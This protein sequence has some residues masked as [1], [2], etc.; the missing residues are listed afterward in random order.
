MKR[1]LFFINLLT[2]SLLSAQDNAALM[3]KFE[4]QKIEYNERFNAYVEK[5]YGSYRTPATLKEIEELRKNLAGFAPDGKPY[6]YQEY[7]LDQVKNSNADFIQNGSVNGLTGAFNGEG[8]KYTVFDGGRA[9][10]A[11]ILFDNLPNRVT[12]Y[13]SSTSNYSSHAT[14]VTSFIGSKDL[15][16]TFNT[17]RAVNFRGIAPNSTFNNYSF[18][19]TTLEGATT[20]ST[21][22]QKILLAQPRISNHSY[23]TNPGW[24]LNTYNGANVWLWKSSYDAGNY[25]DL[26]GAYYTDDRDYDKI[27]YDNPSYIMVKSAGNS[28]G[29][30]PMGSTVTTAYY[31]NTAGTLTQFAATD[32][33]PPNNCGLG[34]DCIGSGSLAKNIIIVGATDRITTNDNRYTVSTD[35]VKSSYSSA[36]PRDD[37]GIK[38]DIS[39]TG[40]DVA[41]AATAQDT[42]G[43]QSVTIG[44][45]TSYSAPI[46]TGVIGLWMQIY[47][48]L[49]N[50]AHLDAA[51]AKN[52]MI[53]SALEAGNVGPDAWYGW[54]FI[55]AKKGAE[56]LVGKA[57]NIV[58]FKDEVL[59]SGN[60]DQTVVVASGNE[61]LKVTISWIDPE[62]TNIGTTYQS[63]HNVRSSRLINDLDL[64]ITDLTTNTVYLPWKLSF[65]S[66]LTAVKGDNT[67]D[68]VEQVVIDAPVA[69]RSYK[70]EVSNKG[71]L[72]NNAG[73][74]ASQNYSIIATGHNQVL[75]TE[76][77]NNDS[78]III[79]PTITKDF[80]KVLK[81]PAKST[82]NVYDLSGKLVQ[83]GSINS[84]DVSLDFS[85]LTKG[86][87]IV[88]VKTN[89]KVITKKI[90]KE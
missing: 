39:T 29:D 37:G 40:T 5:H 42:T 6:F 25:F 7:D 44:S 86:I 30:G 81:A 71:A 87:Y 56:L 27:V 52:L 46:V 49:F 75:G 31:Y 35:V 24:A 17:G 26:Q 32:V 90:I 77:I 88:E 82:Y 23:G 54:G 85:S 68:N 58:V 43:S 11:H 57:N 18:S 12:N 59:N 89:N 14:A 84:A 66:P 67:V 73:V 45:G 1:T 22:F 15:T 80:V 48:T 83:N 65:N 64:R 76:E 55:N 69:G 13:E 79:A 20:T 33:L 53:H 74:A 8:I 62:F 4:K 47:K 28:Y 10:A 72:V 51:S 38:P 61:P 63:L 70:I 36:G 3:D 2:I 16:F 9:F 34:Y 21:V 41:S 78:S 19:T 50:D 60:P